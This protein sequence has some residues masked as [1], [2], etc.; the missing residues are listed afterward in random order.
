MPRQRVLTGAQISEL[1]ALPTD[2]WRHVSRASGCQ[3]L[4]AQ[5][6]FQVV[7]KGSQSAPSRHTPRILELLQEGTRAFAL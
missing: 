4:A 1:L 5:V 6:G 3:D 7:L 2:E